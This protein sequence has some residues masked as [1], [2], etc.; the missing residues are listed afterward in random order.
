VSLSQQDLL[1]AAKIILERAREINPLNTDHS[2]NL[3]RMWL[4]TVS[5]V[6]DKADQERRVE[7]SIKEYKAATALSPNNAVLWN[8]WAGLY[9]E[10]GDFA[11]ALEKTD[12][13]LAIDQ[14]FDNTR[15][16]R[17]SVYLR[18]AEP[19][20]A[21]RQQALQFIA[22][23][24]A[25]DTAKI[26]EANDVIAASTEP[27]KKLLK[28]AE[29]ELD[30]ALALNKT[31]LQTINQ[32]VLINQQLEDY[33]QAIEYAKTATQLNENDWTVWRNLA[34]LY[35]EVKDKPKAL[36]S[37]R[38]ALAIAPADQ[39]AGLQVFIQQLGG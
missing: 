26:K 11:K 20:G 36:E 27:W 31:N 17:A 13:S 25:T 28:Q 16:I 38:R 30:A 37:A 35:N 8:E 12:E 9:A 5:V 32:L 29:T 22:T 18:Q 1:N 7:N 14:K 33:P 4:R 6:S 21:Q 3:A 15:L 39:Q 23:A 24:P 10:R 34:L 19:L 2:A